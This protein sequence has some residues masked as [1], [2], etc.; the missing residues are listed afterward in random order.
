MRATENGHADCARLLL[1][2]GADKE[3]KDEVRMI[4]GTFADHYML[5]LSPMILIIL[6]L[7]GV[8]GL[9]RRFARAPLAYM[10]GISM[11]ACVIGRRLR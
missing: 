4:W 3:A 11:C 6:L 9:V 2:A 7:I 8:I 10:R 1:N 5:E